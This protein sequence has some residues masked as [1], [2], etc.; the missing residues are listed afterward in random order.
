MS[1]L[2]S[3]FDAIDKENAT[4]QLFKIEGGKL[5]QA[6][7]IS[8]SV[9]V[10]VNILRKELEKI[11]FITAYSDRAPISILISALGDKKQIAEA[12]FIYWD[13]DL[14]RN[15]M[16]PVK[17]TADASNELKQGKGFVTARFAPNTEIIIH[18][19]YLAYVELPEEYQK[20]LQP[21]YV[22]EGQFGFRALVPAIDKNFI[23]KELE[24]SD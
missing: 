16:Y 17:T 9:F 12:Q 2:T 21:V 3:K 22:F 5:T 8:E 7:S 20:Y 14:S 4:T 19:I 10:R 23:E 6:T 13:V 18:K 11:P 15:G 24:K 1:G